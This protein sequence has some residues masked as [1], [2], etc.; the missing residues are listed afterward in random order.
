[1][2]YYLKIGR[3]ATTTLLLAHKLAYIQEKWQK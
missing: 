2:S 3:T 1:M